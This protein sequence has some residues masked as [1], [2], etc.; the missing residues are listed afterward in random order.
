[1][2]E[3]I[4]GAGL[5]QMGL[6]T[7]ILGKRTYYLPEAISTNS[8]AQEM[9][10]RGE[11]EGALVI[12]DSQTHGKGRIGKS[13]FSPAGGGLWFSLILRPTAPPMEILG[14]IFITGMAV[15]AAVEN[16]TGVRILL[17]WPNDLVFEGMKVGGILMEGKIS[18]NRMEHLI[19]GI[20]INL[21]MKK[22]DFPDNLR[23][24]ATSLLE[25]TGKEIERVRLLQKI[26]EEMEKLYFKFR[27]AGLAPIMERGKLLCFS[28]GKN[29]RVT[30]GENI[31]E[32]KAVD[33]NDKGAL[34]LELDG[35]IKKEIWWA[36][37]VE[38]II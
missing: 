36:D 35:G 2:P 38:R 26:L 15:S 22:K 20:G 9:A 28:L 17:N 10:T 30:Q 5:I 13:W 18:G 6:N 19:V 12:A 3:N 16:L 27:E 34:I 23:D 11:P 24:K 8:I 7:S 29:L 32:G 25:V 21:N 4:L 31:I 33:L 14:L 37:L 1:M